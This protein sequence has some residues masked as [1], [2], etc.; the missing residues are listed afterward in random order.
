MRLYR[1]ENDIAILKLHTAANFNSYIWPVCM[2]PSSETWE[3][4]SGVIIGWGTQFFGGPYSNTLMEVIVPIWSQRRCELS[5]TQRITDVFLCAGAF[6]GG[7]DSCQGDSGGPL[8][9]QLPNR[10]WVVVGIV[11]WGV[12]CGEPNHP[13]IYTRVSTFTDWI[14]NNSVF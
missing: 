5:F 10:R 13:G 7:R 4:Y 6:E 11:S 2:P 3:G 12:R 8:L 1:Y 14:I 9:L